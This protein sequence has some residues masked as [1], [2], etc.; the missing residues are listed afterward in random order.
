MNCAIFGERFEELQE[1]V[2]PADVCSQIEQHLAECT[3]CTALRRDLADLARL[4][5][6]A[7]ESSSMPDALRAKIRQ[8]LDES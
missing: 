3:A 7:R 8:L 1:G 4:C 6:E 2:L 5:R